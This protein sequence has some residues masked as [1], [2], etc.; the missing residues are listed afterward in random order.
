[1]AAASEEGRVVTNG[2]SEYARDRENINGGLL[3]NVTPEDFGSGHPLAGVAF[4]RQLEEAAFRL[5]GG[6][7]AAPCQRVEDFLAG[8]PSTGPGRV[9][10]SY[11]PGVRWTDL[12]QCLPEFVWQTMALAL[13][14]LDGKVRGYAQGDAVLTAVETRSSSPV[15]IIRD[16]SGQCNVRGL[17]PCGEGGLCRRHPVRRRRRHALRGK[18]MGGIR[19]MR[20]IAV[21]E[22]FLTPERRKKVLDTAEKCGFAVDFYGRGAAP[23]QGLEQYEIIY[24]WCNPQDLKRATG[25]KW[26]CCGFAGVD[27]LSDDSLYASPDV[28]LSNS[29]GAYGLTISEHILMVTLMLLRRMPEFQDIVR[30]R[31]WVSELPMRSIYGSRITVLGAGDIGT[32]FARRAKALGAGHICGVSRSGRN[33]DPAYDRMLP[34]EQLDQVLPETEILVMALP[35]VADTVGILSRERIALL[36]RD[37]IVVNVGRGTA[38]DQEA[39]ME[40]LNAGRIAGAALDVVV[41]EPLPRSTPCGVPGTCC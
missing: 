5:G 40:A 26:Y 17:Y 29:S 13:P 41:P 7:Y 18:N 37:A 16:D 34:Q 2:M 30:R 20:K 24:G 32:N 31:E 14:M 33:P 27:Q 12:R 22:D 19:Q 9:I 38:I 4:Q 15:R 10:P 8:R 39:L 1:M 21:M 6:G 35:S 25:L 36:P 28:M 3:V 23:A 11:R